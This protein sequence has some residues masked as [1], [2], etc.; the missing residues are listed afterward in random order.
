MKYDTLYKIAENRRSIRKFT[1]A[2]VSRED[3]EKIIKTGMLAPSAF[4]AQ[5]WEAVVVDD[6]DLRSAVAQAIIDTMP[7]GK[8]STGFASAPAF[9]LLYGDERTRNFGPAHLKD[10]DAWWQF[11]FNSSLAAAFTNMQLAVASLD[12]G[13]M[14]V[15][16]FRNPA[17][18][19]ATQELLDIPEHLRIFEMMAVGHPAITPGPK[20][21]R[22]VDDVIHYNRAD[23]YRSEEALRLRF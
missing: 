20:K 3:L 6:A 7:N 22:S 18:L 21:L 8:G 12:L 2:P 5:M 19:K 16:A 17:V 4:N 9:I 11:S 14:W 13:S 10:N 23:N 1:N 15:S